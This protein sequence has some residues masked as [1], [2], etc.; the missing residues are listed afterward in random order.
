MI[1]AEYEKSTHDRH[2]DCGV[3]HDDGKPRTDLLPAGALLEVARVLE[4]GAKKY[5]D[6]NWRNVQPRSRYIG[7]LLRHLFAWMEGEKLDKESGLNHVYHAACCAL[8]LAQ[9]EHEDEEAV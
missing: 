7:A 3:K 1:E 9:W 8:F 4:H 2:S 6:N 5:G